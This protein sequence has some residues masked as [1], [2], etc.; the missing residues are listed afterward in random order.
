MPP[1]QM[2]LVGFLQ[3][4]NCTNLA[5][6]WRHPESRL[7]FTSADFYQEIARI[8]EAGRFDIGFFD[9]RLSMPDRYGNDHHHT[10][11]HGIRCVKLD[12]IVTL[13]MMAAV[14]KHL[15]LGSTGSTTYYEPFHIARAFQTLDHMSGGRAA[16][17]IVTSLNDG[18]AANMGREEVMDHDLRYDRA[19]E[20]VEVV[21]GHWNSW[22]D[23]TLI[24]DQKT[25]R[26]ADG[27]KVRRLD[28]RGR[29][30]HSRGPFTVPRSPQGHPVLMQ[31]GASGRGK[32]FS[33]RWAELVFVAYHD[34]ASGRQDYAEFKGLVEAA[35]RDPG[36][37][38]VATLCYPIC[39]ATR[40]EAEDKAAYIQTLP[41]EIDALSLLSE[42]LN[43][44]FA[45]KGMDERF[46]DAEMASMQG[47]QA[48]RD[49]VVKLAGTTNPTTRQ[50]I[51]LSGRGRPARPWVG[52][53]KEVADIMEQWFTERACDGFVISA[54]YVPG[55]YAD[56]VTF[57]V[58]ELQLRGLHR[59]EYTGPTLRD[60]LG[61]RV[62]EVPA[63][64]R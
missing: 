47:L 3:A 25:G 59:R 17:N 15:G 10:L 41:L 56:F 13:T 30:L 64:T 29:F 32:R 6:S 20:F 57:V 35:G 62:P 34:I 40:A 19:D 24:L 9:D 49:R 48:I 16:W 21:V 46:T 39:A 12:P 58:P 26:F 38:K 11:E 22:R 44:D 61:L 36:Q 51:E 7:D 43:F 45:K 2:A 31:A 60:H 27:E 54:T 42:A 63:W 55:S 33:A 37:V 28:Y 18:E 4:Q 14:T 23:D 53:P 50:F 52:G 1:R 8:L 5:A